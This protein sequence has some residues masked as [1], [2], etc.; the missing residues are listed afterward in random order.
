MVFVQ[1]WSFKKPF[2]HSE[3]MVCLKSGS[4]YIPYHHMN[5][6][7][8]EQDLETVA[9]SAAEC[10]S[11]NFSALALTYLTAIRVINGIFNVSITSSRHFVKFRE[12]NIYQGPSGF[13]RRKETFDG[14]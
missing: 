10:L 12:A 11:K 8:A 14:R 6:K 9:N 1:E 5:V 4:L 2:W 13:V 3:V 7:I